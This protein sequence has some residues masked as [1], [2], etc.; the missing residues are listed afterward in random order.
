MTSG[1]ACSGWTKPVQRTFESQRL[2]LNYWDWGNEQAKPLVLL[3][4][5][6]DH[7]RSWDWVAHALSPSWHVVAPDLRGHGDSQWS[8]EGHYSLMSYLYDLVEFM[9]QLSAEPVTIVSHSLGAAIALRYAAVWPE[10]VHSLVAIE[11]ND[12]IA[13]GKTAEHRPRFDTYLRSAVETWRKVSRQTHRR[14]ASLQEAA[15]RMRRDHASLRSDIIDHLT[16]H[17]TRKNADGSY[18]WKFDP[19][20]HHH[21]ATDFDMAELDRLWRD[22]ALPILLPWGRRSGVEDPDLNGFAD[23]FKDARAIAFDAGHWPHHE[24]QDDFIRELLA[25]LQG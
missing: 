24:C 10:R 14:Y 25:F 11:G 15:E 13:P 3:H 20:V 4:G 22:L 7:S 6:R 9:D 21:G 5:S 18:S 19:C 17:G 8:P 2:H 16:L 1:T 23:L 12:F